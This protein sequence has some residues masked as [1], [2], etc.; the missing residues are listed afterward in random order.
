MSILHKIIVLAWLATVYLDLKSIINETSFICSITDNK[1]N[2][3][4]YMHQM[5]L[6]ED[7][8]CIVCRRQG[9]PIKSITLPWF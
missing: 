1:N 5:L 3:N 6:N 2:N 4:N 7:F 8:K 9:G